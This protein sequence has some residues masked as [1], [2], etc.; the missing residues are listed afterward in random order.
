MANTAMSDV[1]H[2]RYEH[3]EVKSEGNVDVEGALMHNSRSF[4]ACCDNALEAGDPCTKNISYSRSSR[5]K[6]RLV[7][8][9]KPA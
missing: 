4:V 9:G 7:N 5:L 6:A 1:S 8:G 3:P 2:H